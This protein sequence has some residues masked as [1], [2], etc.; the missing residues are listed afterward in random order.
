MTWTQEEVAAYESA[1]D[2]IGA[3]I[4]IRSAWLGK[5]RKKEN[6]DQEKIKQWR[7][8]SSALEGE[9][10]NLSLKD[11]A[12]IKAVIDKYTPIIRA[13]RGLEPKSNG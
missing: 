8:E 3:M 6:P 5:E 7:A 9:R 13:D 2:A 11:Q 4:S 12:A 10:H 1:C